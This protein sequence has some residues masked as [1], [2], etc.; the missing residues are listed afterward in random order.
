MTNILIRQKVY[1]YLYNYRIN[2]F[3]RTK[4]II[5]IYIINLSIKLTRTKALN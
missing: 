4:G 5:T 1:I 2:K 3:I